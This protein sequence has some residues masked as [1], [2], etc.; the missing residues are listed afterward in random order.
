MA[1]FEWNDTYSVQVREIDSQ[2]KKLFEITNHFHE[3]MKTGADDDVIYETLN[4]LIKY[5]EEHF[6][7]YDN[8]DEVLDAEKDYPLRKPGRY[9]PTMSN[10]S[11]SRANN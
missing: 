3:A 7:E 4:S 8:L 1:F 5:V 10:G 9:I 2:H 11:S 6:R